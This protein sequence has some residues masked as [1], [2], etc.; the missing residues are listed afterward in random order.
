MELSDEPLEIGT[1]EPLMA[2]SAAVAVPRLLCAAELGGEGEG[3]GEG[4]GQAAALVEPSASG[5]APGSAPPFSGS[6]ATMDSVGA[7]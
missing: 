6:A 2:M 4:E 1:P 5:T 7:G 3:E